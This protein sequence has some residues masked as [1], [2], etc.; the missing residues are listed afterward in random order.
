MI[1]QSL[2]VHIPFCKHICAYC[3]FA[4]VFYNETWADAYLAALEKE[5]ILRAG[6]RSFQTVY[7]GGGSPSALNEKQL[8]KLF[9]I[10][11][12]PLCHTQEATIEVNP[13]DMNEAKAKLFKLNGIN[14]VS[15]GVQTFQSHLLDRLGRHHCYEDVKRC[16]EILE[17]VGIERLSFDLIYGLPDQTIDDLKADLNLL[18]DFPQVEHLS[19]YTLILE[20]HTRFDLEKINLKSDDWLLEG[21]AL[22]HQSLKSNGFQRYEVSNYAKNGQ[23]SLHNLV[24]WH[25][26]KYLGIGCGASGY[27]EDER[28][29]NTKSLQQ[30]LRGITTYQQTLLT[31]EDQMFES[32]MLGLRLCKGIELNNFQK[33]HHQELLTVY[34]KQL[35]PYLLHHYLVIEDGYL[36]TTAKG[37]DI[38]D[39]IL[40][41]LM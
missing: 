26:E 30:Y 40:L 39:E 21:Q 3:D 1:P 29:D 33:K 8:T 14:R 34:K 19:F 38:L 20:P 41:A 7:I 11:K 36:K 12:K 10:L 16:V 35:Q 25:N 9:Q 31:K 13:E 17:K 6:K 24:Y 2:Y 4:K 15:I 18:R 22:I 32:L 37:M 5:L 23:E 27:I 28:Y